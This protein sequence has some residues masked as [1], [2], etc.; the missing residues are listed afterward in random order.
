[1]KALRALHLLDVHAGVEALPFGP[2]DHDAHARVVA[3]SPNQVGEL[4]PSGDRER[5]DRRIVHHD[6]GDAV[7][8]DR[9]RDAH[10][11]L[12]SMRAAGSDGASDSTATLSAWPIRSTC[13][14][15][16]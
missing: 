8:V 4:E 9:V 11:V 14:A 5:V 15:T 3:E 6:L 1:M 12:A 16:S 10:R 7:A 13:R 2:Q